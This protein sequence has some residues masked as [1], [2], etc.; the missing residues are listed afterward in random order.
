MKNFQ[1]KEYWDL[2]KEKL[3]RSYANLSEEDLQYVEGKE[4]DLM[5]RLQQKLGKS[6]ED[7]NEVLFL[8]LIDGDEE[9]EEEMEIEKIIQQIE[10]NM[11]KDR[12][13]ADQNS[14]WTW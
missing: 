9:E 5:H 6:K 8:L 1:Q 3:Q 13:L 10:K 11:A 7:L 4:D 2:L 12:Y 14:T